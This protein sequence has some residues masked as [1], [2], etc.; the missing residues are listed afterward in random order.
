MIL[1]WML[2]TWMAKHHHTLFD[3]GRWLSGKDSGKFVFYS[4]EFL[5]KPLQNSRV[6]LSDCMG[7]QEILY[8]RPSAP[9]HRLRRLEFTYS[10]ADKG[11]L[12]I[13]LGKQRQAVHAVRLSENDRFPS[14][15][16]VFNRE[17]D[18]TRFEP[19]ADPTT[20]SAH[21]SHRGALE[22]KDDRLVLTVDSQ[23]A[24]EFSVPGVQD[25]HF[26]FR[27]SGNVRAPVLLHDVEITFRSEVTPVREW[28]ERESFEAALPSATQ[29]WAVLIFSLSTVAL[30]RMRL[31]RLLSGIESA[32]RIALLED[33]I[34]LAA[35][36]L[37][38]ATP[39]RR[40]G[41]AFPLSI[42]IGE[43]IGIC[44]HAISRRTN[45]RSSAGALEWG[46]LAL[47][48]ALLVAALARHGAALGRATS[49]DPTQAGRIHSAA[50]V[51]VPDKSAPSPAFRLSGPVTLQP[52]AA[53]VI[54]NAAYREQRIEASFLLPTN[55][56]MDVV[57]QQQGYH[58][59]NDV[60]GEELPL[61]RRLLRFTVRPGVKSGLALGVHHSPE[62]FLPFSF[63][64]VVD[65]WNS[66]SVDVQPYAVE[67]VLNGE[68]Q[69]FSRVRSLGAGETAFL[70][71][72]PGVR[73]KDVSVTSGARRFARNT[74]WAWLG[75]LA[76]AACVLALW[77]F[78]RAGA[79]VTFSEVLRTEALCFYPVIL[80]LGG[81]LLFSTESLLRLGSV[82]LGW[83]DL[84]A[85]SWFLAHLHHLVTLRGRLKHAPLY[86]NVVVIASIGG[87]VLFAWDCLLPDEHVWKVKVRRASVAPADAV[88][89]TAGDPGPWYD[90]NNPPVPN[91]FAWKQ[92]FGG[93]PIQLQKEPGRIRIFTMGGSQ[94]WGSG[95]ACTAET[96]DQLL[97][98][99]L[100]AKGL[101]VDIYN[102][103]IN[104][105]GVT[106]V[107]RLFT[108]L[109]T[110]F[111]PDILVLDLGLND[112]SGLLKAKRSKY[113][114]WMTD[115]LTAELETIL[116][117]CKDHEIEVLLVLEP[118]CSETPLRP[119][120][121]LY[122]RFAVATEAQGFTVLQPGS[123]CREREAHHMLWWD[124]A[125]FA[126][127]GHHWFARQLEQPLE[128]LVRKRLSPSSP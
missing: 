54:E 46:L 125:H 102:A 61:Q 87:L 64:P 31:T 45:S 71:L 80:C 14:G 30:R 115:Q 93:K 72:E 6:N 56:S 5:F 37:L 94:A 101:P 95:A 12:W 89:Q 43:C 53:Q 67:V 69:R 36:V 18:L 33:L 109:V 52:G 11:Y 121:A 120:R 48:T 10:I 22:L 20:N 51:P 77:L 55:G 40:S 105:A 110:Q 122:N 50:Y 42:L 1:A 24:A 82:R 127:A 58:T 79:R 65:G 99:G 73:L 86:G 78:L 76:P 17:G 108:G 128:T 84:L 44:A 15:L 47:V 2:V 111:D 100:R 112:S 38:A 66:L 97:Q 83:L 74:T 114:T 41:L 98:S 126:P 116:R 28:M 103:G 3:N 118:M 59:R 57:F 4:F 16:H 119:N 91:T 7:F 25:G 75:S 124:T 23:P 88:P 70:A 39:L 27:G 117:Y 34:W 62:P 96:Y 21:R 107:R 106:T 8:H 85:T 32:P 26:G 63:V 123:A 90:Q 81:S 104:G 92:R 49:A 60:D 19:M 29:A 35:L 9:E 113:Q 13:L 68:T